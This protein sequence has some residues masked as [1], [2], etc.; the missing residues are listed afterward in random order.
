[1][2]E[3]DEATRK[4]PTP[5]ATSPSLTAL[6]PLMMPRNA[7]LP[8]ATLIRQR[9]SCLALDGRTSIDSGTFYRELDCLLPRASVAPWRAVPGS[10]RIHAAI[11]VH[12][13]RGPEPG[14]S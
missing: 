7:S 9:R 2:D 13:V 1:I 4:P 10:P 5:V 3:V 14:P 8:A 11:F 12:R 6:P